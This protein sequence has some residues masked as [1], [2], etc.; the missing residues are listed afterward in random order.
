MQKVEELTLH[1]IEKEK[2]LRNQENKVIQWES[3]LAQQEKTIQE[4]LK[5]IK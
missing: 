1:L 5:K 2:Q 3:K 4:I